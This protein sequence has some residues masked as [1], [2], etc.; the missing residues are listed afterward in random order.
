M[1][2]IV[3]SQLE[4]GRQYYLEALTL[5]KNNNKICSYKSIATFSHL[6]CM[7]NDFPDGPKWACFKYFQQIENKLCKGYD[8]RLHESW[9]KYYEVKKH[10]IQQNME[11]KVCDIML[12]DI[13]GDEY[14]IS[15]F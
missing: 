1:Q 9:W 15:G 6:L 11:T 12:R 3:Q 4:S 7:N 13:T 8:V 5:D 2:E 14:F 10:N